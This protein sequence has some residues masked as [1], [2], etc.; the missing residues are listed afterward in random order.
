M[1]HRF[2]YCAT[3]AFLSRVNT[4]RSFEFCPVSKTFSLKCNES[5]LTS[6]FQQWTDKHEKNITG[7]DYLTSHSKFKTTVWNSI[8]ARNPMAGMKLCIFYADKGPFTNL[9]IGPSC[10]KE[11]S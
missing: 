8:C 1:F 5:R 11:K 4:G 6:L 7:I 2:C 3:N 9:S 10:N